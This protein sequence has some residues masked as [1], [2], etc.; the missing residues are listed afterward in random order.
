MATQKIN[1]RSPYFITATGTEG[2]PEQELLINIVQ[3]NADGTERNSPGVGK[4]SG[5]RCGDPEPRRENRCGCCRGE[6]QDAPG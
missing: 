4:V 5:S 1:S 3:V 6:W 2:T